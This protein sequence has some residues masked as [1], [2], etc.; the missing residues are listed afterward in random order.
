[1]FGFAYRNENGI[2]YWNT[3]HWRFLFKTGIER[4]VSQEKTGKTNGIICTFF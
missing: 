3:V 4:I 2:L 1:M